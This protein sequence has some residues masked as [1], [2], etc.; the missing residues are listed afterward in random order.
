VNNSNGKERA[1]ALLEPS[2]KKNATLE[3]TVSDTGT[4]PKVRTAP[5]DTI[6]IETP[7]D[8]HQVKVLEKLEAVKAKVGR[9][10][11]LNLIEA[12][13]QDLTGVDERIR[14][15][16]KLKDTESMRSICHF[17]TGCYRSLNA[18]EAAGVCREMGELAI[19]G[20]WDGAAYHSETLFSTIQSVSQAL[21]RFRAKEESE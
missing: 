20:N 12:Y 2:R 4:A 21:N 17:L 10:G 8:T 19:E 13:Y 16:I 11:A 15:A 14:T 7:F 3:A 1:D 18:R 9:T 5:A 6:A